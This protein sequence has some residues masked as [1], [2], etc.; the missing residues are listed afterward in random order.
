M[1]LGGKSAR[2]WKRAWKKA[3][4]AGRCPFT[5]CDIRE[6]ACEHL[7]R[8]LNHGNRIAATFKRGEK[9]RLNPLEVTLLYT[10]E[11]EREPEVP[12][13]GM[14]AWEMFRLLRGYG[15][16]R[17]QIGVLIR[18]F[19]FDMT[20]GQI[21]EEMGWTHPMLAHRRYTRALETLKKRGYR[22]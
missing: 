1:G 13:S 15:L 14:G 8:Y 9:A 16:A 22:G 17:D 3:L 7:N 11:I 20:F 12:K 2:F 6:H 10:D 5:G 4:R 19:V 18:V 21:S